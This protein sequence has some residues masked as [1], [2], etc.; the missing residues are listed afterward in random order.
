MYPSMPGHE[1]VGRVTRVG[2]GVTRFKAGDVVAVGPVTDSCGQCKPCQDKQEQY[3]QGPKGRTEAYN[4][5]AKPDGTNTYG[6]Y[7]KRFVVNERFAYNIPANL[8]IKAVAPLLCA[9]MTVYS[10]L[11]HWKA[12]PGMRVGVVGMGGLGHMAVKF[13]VAMGAEVTV[14]STSA[15]KQ[16]D[17]MKFGAKRFVL[18]MD[19][20]AMKQMELSQN[21]LINTIP[22]PYDPNKY[23][24]TLGQDG[25]LIV[26][27]LI[28]PFAV[29]P[30]STELIMHRRAIVGSLVGGTSEYGPYLD[31]CGKNNITSTV[32]MIRLEDVNEA[33]PRVMAAKV[34]Y[35]YVIDMGQSLREG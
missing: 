15:E 12:G 22:Y 1:F 6:G 29:P 4:G 10:P 9:G 16:A 34:R 17:A 32:E 5:P 27:G 14:F 28:M 31:F 8:D 25:K 35:R 21:L 20:P 13:A 33:Y 18:S 3:C 30:D 23:V 2:A 7:S 24:K 19:E 26:V 11:V